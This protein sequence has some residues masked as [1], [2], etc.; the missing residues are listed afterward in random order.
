VPERYLPKSLAEAK[1]I[2]VNQNPNVIRALYW[3]QE[4]R[5]VVDSIFGELLPQF[6]VNGG[7]QKRFRE[8]QGTNDQDDV[9]VVGLLNVPIYQGGE[10]RARV[11]QAKHEHVRRIQEVA[12]R[13]T[14]ARE[15]AVAAWA[16]LGA[17]RA[18]LRSDKTSVEAN[19][20]A[21][22]GVREE[23]K[24]GQRT[25][26][27]VLN[28]EQELLNSQVTLVETERDLVVSAY[29]VLAATG[30]LTSKELGLTKRVYDPEAHYFDVRRKWFGI[31]ITHQD[32]RQ[33]HVNVWKSH[34]EGRTYK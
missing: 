16:E 1:D 12:Q 3:E 13:R 17:R 15:R 30:R 7:Y 20:I 4:A 18:K 34:G 9:S 11:R 23:E 33:E 32:G 14:E 6:R 29:A 5:Y 21:L 19:Q 25:L 24:V 26:L 10:V 8:S 31:S 2:A 27:D 22:A 28:A